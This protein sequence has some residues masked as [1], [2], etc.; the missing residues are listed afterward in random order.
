MGS[1]DLTLSL[2][3]IGE[4]SDNIRHGRVSCRQCVERC[5]TEFDRSE[6][7]I[8]AWVSLDR[9]AALAVANE[10]DAEVR[11]GFWRGPLHGIP[12]GIKDIYDIGGQVTQSGIPNLSVQPADQ[13]STMVARLRRAGAIILGKTVTTAYA[14]FDPPITRNPWN[15]ERTPGGSSSGS[16]AAVASGMCLG[17]LGSQTGGS[18]TRPA[19]FCG[20]AGYKPTFGL[21]HRKGIF[22]FAPNLDHPGPMART[23]DDVIC[24]MTALAPRSLRSEFASLLNDSTFAGP[25]S[26][27][28]VVVLEGEFANKTEPV[29]Q[30]ALNSALEKLNDAT[31]SRIDPMELDLTNLWRHHRRVMAVEIATHQGSKLKSHPDQLTPAIEGLIEEGMASSG[32]DYAAALQFQKTIR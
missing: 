21:L 23:V 1:R 25:S 24:L 4:T 7:D 10:R 17:A 2:P 16:A 3:T 8:Q 19:S 30:A 32:V 18:I 15:L 26:L 6:R 11:K 22:P 28:K 12:V 9:D 31:V 5:L 27:P 14:Y 20:I 13:D 29:M